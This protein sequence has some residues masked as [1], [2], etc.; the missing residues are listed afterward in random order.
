MY[1]LADLPWLWKPQYFLVESMEYEK[2]KVHFELAPD[3][4]GISAYTLQIV[5]SDDNQHGA[6]KKIFVVRKHENC[7]KGNSYVYLE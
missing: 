2:I 4:Y 7:S 6:E 3:D 5:D 1:I